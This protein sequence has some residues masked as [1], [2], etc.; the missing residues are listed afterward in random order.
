MWALKSI[1]L[2]IAIVWSPVPAWPDSGAPDPALRYQVVEVGADDHLNVREHP[3]VDARVLGSLPPDA[4]NVV[5]TG[6]VMDVGGADWWEIVFAGADRGSGW[7]NGRFLQPVDEEE[8]DSDYPLLCS[9]TEPF[10]SLE[11]ESGQA[12]Y[13]G[14]DE[15]T[16]QMSAGPWV[17][18][19]GLTGRFAVELRREAQLG[20]AS[21]WRERA[22]CSD[23]MSDIRYPFGT[24]LIRPDGEVMAGC[25]RRSR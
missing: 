5:V 7:V 20:Y 22:Y 17:M 3:G 2:C 15:K 16:L 10:W 11:L 18:A 8:R 9:G 21:V 25:C 14:M 19:R 4:G 24:I 1:C 23:G 6:S 12:V 13:S